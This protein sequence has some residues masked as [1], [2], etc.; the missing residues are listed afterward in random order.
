LKVSGFAFQVYDLAEY[1]LTLGFEEKPA[2]IWGELLDGGNDN[3]CD[4]A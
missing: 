3:G 2:A 1:A 4:F